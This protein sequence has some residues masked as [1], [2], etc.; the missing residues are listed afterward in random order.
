MRFI[1]KE[2]PTGVIVGGPVWS[3]SKQEVFTAE[4]A[5]RPTEGGVRILVMC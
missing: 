3:R 1:I 5:C 2:A 4:R